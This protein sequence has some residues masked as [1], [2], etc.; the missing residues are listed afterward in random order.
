[1]SHCWF[2]LYLEREEKTLSSSSSSSSSSGKA[3]SQGSSVEEKE[4]TSY[5]NLLSAP[6][7][8]GTT[9]M[10]A[11]VMT[12]AASRRS[13]KHTCSI[14]HNGGDMDDT[15]FPPLPF[16]KRLASNINRFLCPFPT[17]QY[18]PSAYT[19]LP[20]LMG[21]RSAQPISRVHPPSSARDS[22]RDRGLV[23]SKVPI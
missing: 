3:Q 19:Q 16:S 10:A 21:T 11:M 5:N 14:Q 23:A 9:T 22:L 8:W 15:F 2:S 7:L 12:T 1:M 17:S 13:I 18:N 6:L 20:C 4:A